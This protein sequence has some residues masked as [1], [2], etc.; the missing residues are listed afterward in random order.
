VEIFF[1]HLFSKT[2]VITTIAAVC[3]CKQIFTLCKNVADESYHVT[4]DRYTS[5]LTFKERF[6]KM[7]FVLDI[8]KNKHTCY[9]NDMSKVGNDLVD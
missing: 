8:S 9:M 2:V 5:N 3:L 4:F 6:R 7:A 1:I